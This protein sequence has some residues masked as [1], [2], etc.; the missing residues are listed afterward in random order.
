MALATLMHTHARAFAAAFARPSRITLPHACALL[1]HIPLSLSHSE[2]RESVFIIN[3]LAYRRASLIFYII[4]NAAG[5]YRGVYI[6]KRMLLC[7][8]GAAL[9]IGSRSEH[10]PDFGYDRRSSSLYVCVCVN[11]IGG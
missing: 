1:R 5:R 3:K 9:V 2:E 7:E 8:W 6:A 10:A 11:S 4:L